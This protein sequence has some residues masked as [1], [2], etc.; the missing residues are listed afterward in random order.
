[1][2][3]CLVGLVLAVTACAQSDPVVTH[4]RMGEPVGA[5]AAVYLTVEGYGQA[6][7]LIGASTDAAGAVE[8][9]ETVIGSNGQASMNRVEYLDLPARGSLVLEPGGFHIML[10]GVDRVIAG[11]GITITLLWEHAGEMDVDVEVVD[12]ADVLE[13]DHH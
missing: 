9:H 7:R 1:M 2:K 3:V 13:H 8:L 12:P 5:N 10:L 4:A 6:D 11:D